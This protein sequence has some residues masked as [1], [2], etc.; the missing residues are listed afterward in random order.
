MNGMTRITSIALVVHTIRTTIACVVLIGA[1]AGC[2][3]VK[4]VA[5][6]TPIVSL[7]VDAADAYKLVD[8]VTKDDSMSDEEVRGMMNRPL[9]KPPGISFTVALLRRAAAAAALGEVKVVEDAALQAKLNKVEPPLLYQFMDLVV[10]SHAWSGDINKAKELSLPL[11]RIY[12]EEAKKSGLPPY[13]WPG[14]NL[15][16]YMVML[17][18]AG[19]T[20]DRPLFARLLSEYPENLDTVPKLTNKEK[21][22]YA[23]VRKDGR[24]SVY[25]EEGDYE[26][27][28]RVAEESDRLREQR[29]EQLY[30][31][32]RKALVKSSI[33]TKVSLA[34]VLCLQRKPDAAAKQLA[35]IRP[36]LK[37]SESPKGARAALLGAEAICLASVGQ[38]RQAL[39]SLEEAWSNA[40]RFQRM[41][42]VPRE[43]HA[44]DKARLQL[45]A[46][47]YAPALATLD[48][49]GPLDTMS[50][51][52]Y[53]EVAVALRAYARAA[54]GQA[55]QGLSDLDAQDDD[56]SRRIGTENARFHFAVKT[57]AHYTAFKATHSEAD[58]RQAVMGGRNFSRAYRRMRST[59]QY[60]DVFTPP[61]LFSRAKE[62]YLLAALS[63]VGKFGVTMDDVLDAFSLF[64][65]SQ[66]D[67]DISSAALRTSIPGLSETEVRRLQDLRLA[68]RKAAK[69]LEVVAK[70]G[71]RSDIEAAA[72]DM[73]LATRSFEDELKRLE[74][75]APGLVQTLTASSSTL[76]EIRSQL[77]PFEALVAFAPT[78]DGTASLVV[79]KSGVAYRVLPITAEETKVLVNRIRRST[80]FSDA[81]YAPPFDVTAA[82][83]LY[84]QLF[85][86][87]SPHLKEIKQLGVVTRGSLASIPFG[88]L[89]TRSPADKDYRNIQW[90]VKQYAITHAPSISAWTLAGKG[91]SDGVRA[92]SF[93]A[94]ADPDFGNADNPSRISTRRVRNALRKPTDGPA[95]EGTTVQLEAV[96][97]AEV[98]PRLP[99]TRTEAEAIAYAIKANPGSDVIVG[100]R[101]TRASVLSYSS[102]GRLKGTGTIMFA[103]HGL[104]PGD[105]SGL[106]QPALAMAV[107]PTD[108]GWPLLK[109]D[110]VVGLRLNADW[111]LLSACNTSSADSI[112]GDSLSG[113]AR[114]FFFAGA[115]SLLVT[116]WEVETESAS[117]ITVKTMEKYTSNPKMTRAQALQAASLDLI[118]GENVPSE[119]AHPVFWAPYA[120][121]GNGRR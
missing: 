35:L 43:G 45:A 21:A 55:Q 73:E 7:F 109:L 61:E 100:S 103:T 1:V 84:G 67:E 5:S 3:T 113:L 78:Q 94:W 10:Y 87:A 42:K 29:A 116:H 9:P 115:K 4:E 93:I 75:K 40:F 107:D 52:Y 118:N 27:A 17:S 85:F 112:G 95:R 90:L 13:A 110:D 74:T 14:D 65:D 106:T 49:M 34:R 91:S 23:L 97:F 83:E 33:A 59:G 47:L 117:A 101:A 79:T 44:R 16:L 48:G 37:E 81:G 119:W 121:V 46:G 38:H 96:N 56:M 28:I 105:L 15:M 20:G 39:E 63:A 22:L 57:F 18:V 80:R 54:L 64:Y 69:H 51:S 114:G 70:Q 111:V 19:G 89:V 24:L 8:S 6:Q 68:A 72:K 86:W 88:L 50:I 99:E 2:A 11:E 58:L 120:L 41:G 26:G 53:R 104:A 62:A 60:G 25:I 30:G 102:A 66:T 76:G 71:D 36:L 92:G 12:R 82:T 32:D 77:L 108:G 98:L 31:D